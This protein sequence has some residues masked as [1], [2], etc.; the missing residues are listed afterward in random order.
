LAV[1]IGGGLS[2]LLGF[3]P[4]LAAAFLTGFTVVATLIFHANFTDQVQQIMFM[5]NLSIIG[6]LLLVIQHGVGNNA[7]SIRKMRG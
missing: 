7:L 3:Y 5:K 6:G 4:R 2:L 1:E